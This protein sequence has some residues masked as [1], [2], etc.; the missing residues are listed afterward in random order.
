MKI[1]KQLIYRRMLEDDDDNYSE[2]VIED[3]SV[4]IEYYQSKLEKYAKE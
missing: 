2:I 1:K 3:N 4:L